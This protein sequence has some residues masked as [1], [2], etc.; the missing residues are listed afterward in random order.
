MNRFFTKIS[1]LVLLGAI[2]GVQG[3]SASD[4]TPIPGKAAHLKRLEEDSSN[5]LS[6]NGIDL[7]TGETYRLTFWAKAS[8]PLVL[9][10]LTKM[11][12]PPWKGF[13]AKT[14]EVDT[15]WHQQEIALDATGTVPGHT[16]LEIRFGGP[17]VG[18]AWIA[19]VRLRKEGD[20]EESGNLLMNSRF[21]EGEGG[22]A[23]WYIEGLKPGVFEVEAVAP[24]TD[25][26]P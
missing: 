13:Q 18:E 20:E 10:V 15:E 9:R 3:V 12:Q 11:D 14:V 21:E 8:H 4:T 19:D 6:Q 2:A 1:A 16:R 5:L 17:E 22:L 7:A 24:E 23:H 26:Q 25:G